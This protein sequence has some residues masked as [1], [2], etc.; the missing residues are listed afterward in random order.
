MRIDPRQNENESNH[1]DFGDRGPLMYFSMGLGIGGVNI[2]NCHVGEE[3]GFW[4]GVGKIRIFMK[5][6][7]KQTPKSTLLADN[8]RG[9]RTTT[10][11]ARQSLL[12]HRITPAAGGGGGKGDC[13]N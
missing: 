4:R 3:G 12:Q 6:K 2:P 9:L 5:R 11:K 10:N 7:N 13:H 8:T 1:I